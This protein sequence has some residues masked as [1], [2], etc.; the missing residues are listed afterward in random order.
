MKLAIIGASGNVGTRLV[1]E[2]LNYLTASGRS[3]LP[4][5]SDLQ[6]DLW[7]EGWQQRSQ[8]PTSWSRQGS[9]VAL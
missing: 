8:P 2:A 9:L 5:A 6:I 4:R 3:P 1:T 7:R